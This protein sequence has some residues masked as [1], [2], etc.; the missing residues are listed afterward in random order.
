MPNRAG[1]VIIQITSGRSAA[2][3]AHLNGVQVVGGSNPPAPTVW[4]TKLGDFEWFSALCF[5]YSGLPSCEV[6]CTILAGG[7]NATFQ[8]CRRL[9]LPDTF[10][11]WMTVLAQQRP[12]MFIMDGSEV[13]RGCLALVVSVLCSSGLAG[14]LGGGQGFQRALFRKDTRNSSRKTV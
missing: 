9:S 11:E 14:S 7:E 13:G 1:A 12:L 6:W 3:L 4:R 2:R 8:G 5:Y 10:C